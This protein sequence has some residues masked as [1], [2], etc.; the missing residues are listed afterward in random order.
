MAVHRSCPFRYTAM[1]VQL[2]VSGQGRPLHQRMNTFHVGRSGIE[3]V[4]EGEAG[5]A[6]HLFDGGHDGLETVLLARREQMQGAVTAFD[7]ENVVHHHR[8]TVDVCLAGGGAI[9][10]SRRCTE[11]MNHGVLVDEAGENV[12]PHHSGINR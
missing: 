10:H 9:N 3:E 2:N 5:I 1:A 4:V 12:H 7:V 8:L 11:A 6:Q